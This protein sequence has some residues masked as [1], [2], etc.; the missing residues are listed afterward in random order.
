MLLGLAACASPH[1]LA[2]LSQ[3]GTAQVAGFSFTVNWNED[4]AEATRTN[5]YWSRD[6]T[7]VRAAAIVA[8]HQVTGCEVREGSVDGDIALVTMR[9]RCEG[10]SEAPRVVC[11]GIALDTYGDGGVLDVDI[12]CEET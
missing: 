5:T 9:L 11:S 12:R 7:P 2:G 6:M 10:A 4:H 3:S 8:V 1:P